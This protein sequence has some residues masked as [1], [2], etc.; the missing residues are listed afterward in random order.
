MKPAPQESLADQSLFSED[1][2]S[3]V[4][5]RV[6]VLIR[7]MGRTSLPAAVRS[8]LTQTWPEVWVKVVVANGQLP[9]PMAAAIDD[10]RVEIIHGTQ[11]L[12]RAAAANRAL[13]AVDTELAIFLDDDDWL[14]PNH[15]ER[16]V[17]A[18][19]GCPDAVAAHAGVECV[20]VSGGAVSSVNIFD[21]DISSTGMQLGNRLP[22]HST[23]FRMQ[24]VDHAP[25]L[26]FNEDLECFEDWD[27]W[28]QLMARGTFTRV[29]G[30]S[31][32]YQLDD[33]LGSGHESAAGQKRQEMLARFGEVQLKR[34]TPSDVARLI[35]A[36]S[37]KTHGLR[38]FESQ[39]EDLKESVRLHTDQANQLQSS[40]NEQT[41]QCAAFLRE[42][43]RINQE[44]AQ[45]TGDL[46]AQLCALHAQHQQLDAAH[47]TV[48]G[49]QSW[50]ITRPLRAVG[51]RMRAGLLRS[52]A[53]DITRLLPVSPEAR[54]RVKISLSQSP[55]GSSVLKWMTGSVSAPDRY[56]VSTSTLDKEAIRAEA[57]RDLGIFL[58][59]ADRINLHRSAGKPLVSVI[60]VLYNQAGLSLQCLRALANSTGVSFET[61]IVDNASV[62]RV[63][64]LMNR[65]DGA[66]ILRQEGN[67]GFLRAVNQAADHAT[68]ENL[69]LLNNDA[70]VEPH[71]LANAVARLASEPDVG[72]VGGPILLWDGRLQEA[73]SI[74]WRDGSCLGY[75]RGDS[76]DSPAYRFVRDVDYCSGAF[77]MVRR[78]LFEQLNR[79]DDAFAPA[80]YEESDFCVRLWEAGHR[81]VYDPKV[82]VKHFEFASD[83][84]GGQAMALQARNRELFVAK[85]GEY[86]QSRPVSDPSHVLQARQI[87]RSGAKRVLIIDDRVP[88]P[89]LG[90]GYPRAGMMASIIGSSVDALTYYPLQIPDALWDD[91]YTVLNPRTEVILD[92]GLAGLAKFLADRIGQFD[93]ILVSRPHNM[94]P[95]AALK[96]LHP[97]WFAGVKLVYDAEALFCLRT[98]ECAKVLGQPL[99]EAKAKS[100]IDEELSL[101]KGAD[102]IVA[103]SHA[104]ELQ[105]RRAGCTDVVVL[106]HAL[107]LQPSASS[108]AQRE[109]F[110]F[111]GAITQDDCPNGDSILWFVREVW[112]LIQNTLGSNCGLDIVGVCESPAVRALNSPTIRIHGRVPD[113]APYFER[114]RVFIAPTRYAAG[115]PHKA[116]EAA[117]RGLPMVVTPLIATQLGWHDELLAADGAIAFAQ[118]CL[119]LHNDPVTWQRV[120]E[121]ALVSV[122]HDCSAEAFQRAVQ[123]IVR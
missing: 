55:A 119:L 67:L 50:R 113:L 61:I 77:L 71:T 35:E 65:M 11:S 38:I 20:K 28:L 18:L 15:I 116:H 43:D 91:V 49:S 56:E 110:L 87:L 52:V 24:V 123:E 97:D 84:G 1:A 59:S 3:V 5:S 111:V 76:P 122:E 42:I 14:L 4:S 7:T 74:I 105:Y 9:L 33:D 66:R 23:L 88:L 25:T 69:L 108:F 53:K 19:Q 17:R 109:G 10:P 100:I 95:L 46:Q 40:L 51:A 80:Y 2:Q 57:E 96:A 62:D 92:E 115:V 103:V 120:R 32:V 22:I 104:E 118:A 83:A 73:G 64:Q 89:D 81:V 54:R 47:R 29:A 79:F 117:S 68:G 70:I 90:R 121:A 85:H 31:A 98:I 93:L 58:D 34:W 102:R 63:P 37:A 48:L 78:A 45:I 112:P 41:Q 106:G 101:A 30:V 13:A 21:E 16:L 107:T 27:F 26:R 86:L 99:S 44:N 36:D 12:L 39:V 82:R 60:I 75:G 94:E 6:C 8:A 72:A 114:R